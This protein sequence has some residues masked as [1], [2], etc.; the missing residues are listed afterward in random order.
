LPK[1]LR[2]PLDLSYGLYLYAFPLQQISAALIGDFWLALAFS[3]SITFALA[4]MSALFIERP[5]LRLKTQLQ[6]PSS[7]RQSPA[8]RFA[9]IA[10]TS[11]G[12]TTAAAGF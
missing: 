9:A 8:Q 7:L 1:W 10:N 3:T 6:F 2:P 12:T 11:A 4:L 5:A